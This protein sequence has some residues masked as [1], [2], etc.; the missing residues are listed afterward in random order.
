MFTYKGYLP[1]V[2]NLVFSSYLRADY[3]LLKLVFAQPTFK[4]VV[5]QTHQLRP[6]SKVASDSVHQNLA[7]PIP[8]SDTTSDTVSP[9]NCYFVPIIDLKDLTGISLFEQLYLIGKVLGESMPLKTII[10]KCLIDQHYLG[11]QYG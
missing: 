8:K 4:Q 6:Y 2:P 10:S 7:I 5:A 11:G 9:L 3:G 1:F